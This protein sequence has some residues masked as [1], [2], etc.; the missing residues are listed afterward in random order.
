[1]TKPNDRDG[2]KGDK[3]NKPSKRPSNGI[4]F[5]RFITLRNGRVLD[6]HDYGHKAWPI[7]AHR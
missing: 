7:G 2:M 5:R 6:A 4:I 1:M 3:P